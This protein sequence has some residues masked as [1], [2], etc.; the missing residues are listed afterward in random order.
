MAHGLPVVGYAGC[1][2]VRE[3]ISD[4]QNG[5][6][7]Q[8]NGSA[9]ALAEALLFLM[10]DDARRQSMGAAATASMRRFAPRAVF[11]RWEDLFREVSGR[12]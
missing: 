5:S 10:K 3:I 12:S 8:G 6:L 9:D 4:G 7:A 2:G 11:D 1:A